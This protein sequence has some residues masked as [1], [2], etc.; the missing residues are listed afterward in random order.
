M[1]IALIVLV[2]IRYNFI[3]PRKKLEKLPAL[4]AALVAIAVVAAIAL[5]AYDKV[6]GA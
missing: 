3:L 6:V 1:V 4:D 5:F 2:V